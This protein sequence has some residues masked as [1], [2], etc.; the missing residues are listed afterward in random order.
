M[1]PTRNLPQALILCMEWPPR[2][3]RI[4]SHLCGPNLMRRERPYRL[5]EPA[6][7]DLQSVSHLSSK[8]GQR[9]LDCYLYCIIAQSMLVFTFSDSTLTKTAALQ[10]EKSE[11]RPSL[12]MLERPITGVDSM[13]MVHTT[14]RRRRKFP[15]RK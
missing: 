8:Q 9:S 10:I 7:V 2:A 3:S 14:E 15:W 5:T 11:H 12:D 1:Q 13:E 4:R 6:Y